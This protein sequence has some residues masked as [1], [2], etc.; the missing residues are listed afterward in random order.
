MAIDG[1]MPSMRSTS[2]FSIRSRNCRAYAESDSTYRRCPSAY[3]V[4]NASDALPE[5][6]T[7]VITIRRPAG[8]LTSIFWRL[9]VRAPRTTIAPELLAAGCMVFLRSLDAARG[10]AG[11]HAMLADMSRDRVCG[12]E[13]P[14]L[15]RHRVRA[16]VF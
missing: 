16:H 13:F 14:R 2:G 4:S 15:M 12:D 7:P 3:T 10:R 11:K 8:K 6:L 1:Q 5:P 9:W